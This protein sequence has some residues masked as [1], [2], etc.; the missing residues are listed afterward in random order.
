MLAVKK[1]RN[2]RQRFTGPVI[3]GKDILELLSSAMYVDPLTIYREFVQNAADALDEAQ[4]GG[5]FSGD[6][7]PRIDITIDIE[8][9]IINIRDNGTGIPRNWATRTL[10]SL[11]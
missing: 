7:R 9:R 10:T 2:S 4:A 6:I 1:E 11:G 3:V 5:L 8:D